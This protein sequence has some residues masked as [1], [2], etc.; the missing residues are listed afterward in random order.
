MRFHPLHDV[1]LVLKTIKLESEKGIRFIADGVERGMFLDLTTVR[2]CR[3]NE[4]VDKLS[5]FK[6]YKTNIFV[7]SKF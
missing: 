4:S 6:L 1:G 3:I 5:L 2:I 7:Y